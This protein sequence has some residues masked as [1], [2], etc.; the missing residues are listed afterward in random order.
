MASK[1]SSN[2]SNQNQCPSPIDVYALA[3]IDYRVRRL[4]RRFD[5]SEADQEDY[6]NDM[7]VELQ[8]ALRR[9]DPEKSKRETF[10]N[11][12]LDRYL[13][14]ATR[15]RCTRLRRSCENPLGFDDIHI[16]YEPIDNDP[17][18][19]ELSEQG[20]VGLH[21]DMASV[22]GGMPKRLQRA[23]RLL[24]EFEPAEVAGRLGIHRTSIYR[25]IREIRERFV[26][27]G[28]G[29]WIGLRDKIGPAADVGGAPKGAH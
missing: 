29:D 3:R 2:V 18:H 5:L 1:L 26:A 17:S 21:I 15:N 27:A 19:G 7:V 10:I 28:L 4:A 9:F 12:V 6:R 23:C 8:S 22:I 14:Y 16:G 20:H 11:R 13:A 25:I 24:Q